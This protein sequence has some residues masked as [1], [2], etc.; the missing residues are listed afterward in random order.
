M[1]RRHAIR[2]AMLTATAM[3]LGKM[4]LLKAEGGLLTVPLDA[5]QHV[6]FVRRGQ[7]ISISVDEIFAALKAEAHEAP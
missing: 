3:C 7:R 1:T 6:V 4:D 5:W 2:H